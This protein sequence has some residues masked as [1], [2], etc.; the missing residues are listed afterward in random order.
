MITGSCLCTPF[1]DITLIPNFVKIG[2]AV[3]QGKSGD[4]ETDTEILGTYPD[5]TL[6]SKCTFN[7]IG[8]KWKC[9]TR[10]MKS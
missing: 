10:K 9:T 2:Q 3:Q 5:P 4:A 7:K 1:N 8:E 6:N